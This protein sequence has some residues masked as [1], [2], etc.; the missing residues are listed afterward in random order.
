MTSACESPRF[1]HIGL[2]YVRHELGPGDDL[3]A[4][5]EPSAPLMVAEL[6]FTLT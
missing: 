6:P 2:A 5:E 4:Q 3:A 1:G